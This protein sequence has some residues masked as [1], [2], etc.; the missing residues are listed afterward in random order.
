M[1]PFALPRSK[2]AAPVLPA[3]RCPHKTTV[4]YQCRLAAGHEA[5]GIVK[6]RIAYSGK[7]M[8]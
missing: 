8:P 6:H 3:D 5:K 4:G 2:V 7:V 1:K